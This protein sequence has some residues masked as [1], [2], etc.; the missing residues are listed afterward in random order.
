MAKKIKITRKQIKQD[1]EFL[2]VVKETVGG[3]LE[4]KTYFL[5][6]IGGLLA[7]AIVWGIL[8]IVL[9]SSAGAAQKALGRGEIIFNAPVIDAETLAKNPE[10]RGRV[11]LFFTTEAERLEKSIEA[12]EDVADEFAGK[13]QGQLA[14]VYEGLAQQNLNDCSAA[15]EAYRK[16]LDELPASDP[17][18]M[19]AWQGIGFCEE[20]GGDR[21][22]A[23]DAYSKLTAGGAKGAFVR[24]GRLHLARVYEAA[25]R[26]DDA[27][28]ELGAYLSENAEAADKADV[29]QRIATLQKG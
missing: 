28:R 17:L 14:L 23:I 1:D 12:F 13:R 6:G 9:S 11:P 10:I 4:Y 26:K 15:K 21:N 2:H 16:A 7:V 24:A 19:L 29:E 5:I 18:A 20:S 8:T 22:A 27:A 3:L 25:G